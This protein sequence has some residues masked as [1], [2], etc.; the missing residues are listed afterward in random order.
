MQQNG[1]AA[2]VSSIAISMVGFACKSRPFPA[3][4]TEVLKIT[5]GEPTTLSSLTYQNTSSLAI[6]R[7]GVVAAFYPKP[8]TAPTFYRTSTDNGATWG[9]EM[10]LPTQS[11]WGGAASVA[12]RDGGVLKLLTNGA[13]YLGELWFITAPLAGK[14]EDGWFTLHSTF[15][16]FNDDFTSYEV[17]PVQVYMPDA[18]TVREGGRTEPIFDKGKILQL[19]NGDLLAPMYGMFESDSN[20][21]VILCSSSDRGHTWRYYATVAVEPEDLNPEL[22]GDYRGSLEP[23]IEMLSNGQMICVFRTQGSHLPAQY[24]PMYACWSQDQG[25]TWTKPKPTNPHLMNIW[26]TLQALDNGVLA[27]IYGRPGF[28]VAFSTDNGYT[29]KDRVSFSHLPEPRL[30]GMVDGIKVGPNKLLA[31]GAT[32]QGTQ[33]FPITVERV[34]VSPARVTLKGQVLDQQGNVIAGAKVERGPNRYRA[35]FWQESTKLDPWKH[36]TPLT[37]GSPELGY[38][39]IRKENGYP[40]VGTDE[41]GRFRFDSVKLGEMILT[42]EA[43][44][45]APQWRHVKVGPEPESQ[46]AEFVLKPGQAVRGRL[47]DSDGKPVSGASVVLN[48][49]HVYSD[50]QGFFDWPVENPVPEQVEIKVYKRYSGKYETL[51]ATLPF[52]QL[53]RQPIILPRK[54]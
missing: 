48:M 29:W 4:E 38:R 36:R 35:D 3:D 21:R 14:V 27:C 52:S 32:E 23:G 28:H 43:D 19:D 9:P 54:S 10:D 46:S 51:K 45:F 2:V 7:T 15:T 41:Q 37:V 12:L 50:S 42:V 53:G 22:P 49:W 40:A 24:R 18:V 16:W 31:I 6:S 13:E 39:S 25:K 17:G 11:S 20:G 5:V 30:T 26:P 34:M 47:L 33:V 44:G 8:G 1:L